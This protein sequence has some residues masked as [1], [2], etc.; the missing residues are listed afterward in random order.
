ML[1]DYLTTEYPRFECLKQKNDDSFQNS[2][3]WVN[4]AIQIADSK[5]GGTFESAYQITN[6]IIRYDHDSFL[7]ACKTQ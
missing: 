7:A 1:V 2:K 4:T 3:D 5:H 6:H